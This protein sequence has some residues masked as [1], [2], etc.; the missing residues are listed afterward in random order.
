MTAGLAC[1]DPGRYLVGFQEALR[2]NNTKV[3]VSDS[4]S[5]FVMARKCEGFAEVDFAL[6]F[7]IARFR[8]AIQ[9]PFS[10]RKKWIARTSRA[11]TNISESNFCKV[12]AFAGHDTRKGELA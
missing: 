3:L 6:L 5:N 7:V 10:G 9:F 11:M 12:L 1:C 2:P 8:R 4:F